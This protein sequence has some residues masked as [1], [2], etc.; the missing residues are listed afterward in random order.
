MRSKDR[1]DRLNRDGRWFGETR[2]RRKKRKKERKKEG[3]VGKM[4]HIF[5]SMIGKRKLSTREG[6]IWPTIEDPFFFFFF[7]NKLG[8]IN[9][10]GG[11]KVSAYAI[12]IEE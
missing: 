9:G 1:D 4:I 2:K 10:S 3:K 8:V 7:R 12:E 5:V 11:G 6:I